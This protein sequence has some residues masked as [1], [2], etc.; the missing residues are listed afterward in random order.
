MHKDKLPGNSRDFKKW[1][2]WKHKEYFYFISTTTS[3]ET[4]NNAI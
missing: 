2:F 4:K 3:L 1:G